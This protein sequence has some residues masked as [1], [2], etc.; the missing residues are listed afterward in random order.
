M[1]AIE[2]QVSKDL[3]V[4][5]Q[6][7]VMMRVDTFSV[8]SGFCH[9]PLLGPVRAGRRPLPAGLPTGTPFPAFLF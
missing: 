9:Q 2:G 4:V 7:L 6:R 1:H 8:F 3:D 5:A